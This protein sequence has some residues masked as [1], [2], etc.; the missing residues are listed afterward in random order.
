MPPAPTD[1][2]TNA[3]KRSA[4]CAELGETHFSPPLL[5]L[6]GGG[7]AYGRIAVNHNT[8]IPCRL[9]PMQSRGIKCLLFTIHIHIHSFNY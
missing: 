3:E 4:S 7:L 9:M 8:L 2:R 1:M 5:C 6:Q